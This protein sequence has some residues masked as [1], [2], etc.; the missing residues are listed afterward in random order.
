MVVQVIGLPGDLVAGRREV[1]QTVPEQIVVIGLEIDLPAVNEKIPV[2]DQL[3]GVGQPVLVGAGVFAP[4]VAEIDVDAADCVVGG[5]DA[6]DAL[7]VGAHDPHIVDG[8]AGRGVGG[9]DLPLGQ[10]QHLVGDVDAEVIVFGVGGGQL[11]DKTALA[12]AQFQHEGLLWPGELCVPLPLQVEGVVDVEVGGEQLGPRVGLETHTHRCD[13]PYSWWLGAWPRRNRAT[14]SGSAVQ[15]PWQMPGL[16]PP[17][18]PQ[19]AFRALVRG[20]TSPSRRAKQ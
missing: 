15:L 20:R 13:S 1:S 11:G 5:H 2:L 6:A 8:A 7:D 17:R 3:P 4:G 16:P 10:D 14:V 18:P 19:A 12:A 9:L